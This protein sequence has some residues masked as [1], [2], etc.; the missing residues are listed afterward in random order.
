MQ[1]I[2][3]LDLGV[4]SIGWAI[5]QQNTTNTET[6]KITFVEGGIKIIPYNSS[7]GDD[8]SKG[9]SITINQNRTRC[10]TAK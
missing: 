8:F 6:N 4:S 3:G 7:E 9:K 2:L 10:T 5:I 1:K